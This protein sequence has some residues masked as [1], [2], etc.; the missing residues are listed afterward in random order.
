MGSPLLSMPRQTLLEELRDRL[1][2]RL[3]AIN[4]RLSVLSSELEKLELE[5]IEVQ[6]ELH[7][8][9]EETQKCRAKRKD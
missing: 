3:A 4:K 2:A 7:V 1:S 8:I 9:E 5:R 6:A